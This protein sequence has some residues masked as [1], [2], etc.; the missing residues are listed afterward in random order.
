MSRRWI[1]RPRPSRA[2]RLRQLLQGEGG[3][4]DHPHA[5]GVRVAARRRRRAHRGLKADAFCHSMVRALVGACVEVGEGKLGAERLVVLRDESAGPAPSRSCRRA[6][7]PCWRSAIRKAPA[8]AACRAHAGAARA[9]AGLARMPVSRNIDLWCPRL[10]R[11]GTANVSPPLACSP[12]IEG[13]HP[14]VGFTNLSVR[15]KKAATTVTRTYTPKA[16]EI[17]RDWL[18]IDATDV[19]LGRLA[20]HTAALLRGKHKATFAPTWTPVTSSS[21]STPTRSPSP[22]RSSRRS[23]LPPLG[24]PGRPHRPSPTPSSSRRTR[25]APSRRRSAACSRRTRLGRAQLRKLKVY[26][27]HRAPARRAAAQAVHPRPGRPVTR[28]LHDLETKDYHHRGEDR[29]QHRLGSGRERRS[30]RPRPRPTEAAAVAR[31]PVLSV[32]GAAVGRRKQAIARVRLV[33]G[34][35]TITV[36]GRDVRGLLPEQAAPAARSTTRSRCSTSS[37]PTTS[38]PASP[39]AAPRARPAPCASASP[40]R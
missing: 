4:D 5:A 23:C 21:S 20:S 24:L 26:T 29:R 36:N 6:A 14:G 30:T 27:R 2:S 38:S 11:R 34:S 32:P 8:R 12:F 19:V 40:V 33:P 3:R 22:A 28:Q 35:G 16:G 1:W 18:I 15:Y 37:A 10:L 17:Q 31:A 25:S 39:A 9:V 7:S 13:N